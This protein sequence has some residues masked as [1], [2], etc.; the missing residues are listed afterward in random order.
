M[1]LEFFLQ[2]AIDLVTAKER[3]DSVEHR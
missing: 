1:L 2:I 3:T